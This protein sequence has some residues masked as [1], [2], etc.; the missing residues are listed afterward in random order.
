MYLHIVNEEKKKDD[1][2]KKSRSKIPKSLRIL[3]RIF[4]GILI[5][6]VLLILF[7]RSPW[8]QD[9][10]VNKVVSYISNETNTKVEVE[11]LFVTFAGDIALEGLY[12]EDK[13][14]D[15]LVY[16]KE[17]EADIPF[18]PIIKGKDIVIDAIDLDGLRA[19]FIRKDTI[20]GFNFQ[21]LAD[22]FA[23]TDSTAVATPADSTAS[24]KIILGDFRLK[25]IDVV[26]NDDVTGIQSRYIA[27]DLQLNMEET[28][29]E[30]MTFAA[31]ELKI[32]D[33]KIN[34]L[35]KPPLY[36]S[37]EEVPLPKF[38]VE[39]VDLK[40]VYLNFESNTERMLVELDLDEL[41]AEIP[42]INLVESSFIIDTATLKN[43]E[44]LIHTETEVNAV[45]EALEKVTD[46]V[47]QDIQQFSW[48]AIRLSLKNIDFTNNSFTYLVGD[49]EPSENAFNPNAFALTDLDL[50]AK[51]FRIGDNSATLNL[52]SAT[53]NEIS[54]INLSRFAVNAKIDD[55]NL[56][57]DGLDLVFNGNFVNGNLSMEYPSLNALI[58]KPE[59]SK[60]DANIDRF[61]FDVNEIFK[62][63]PE[64]RK[65]PYMLSFAKK[66]LTGSIN[67]SGYMSSINLSNAT[68]NWGNTTQISASGSI[69]SAMDPD[70]IS[71]NIPNLYAKT[72][73]SDIVQ[74]VDTTGMGINLPKEITAKGSISGSP[75][76]INT[77][78][79]INTSQGV[80]SID[81]TFR[82]GN[83]I[84]FDGN[85][86][87]KQF[88]LQE[89]LN[90]E[91]LGPISVTL[92]AKG[93]GTDINHL[94]AEVEAVIDS[95]Q[96]NSY[97][98]KDLK[99]N[100]SIKNGKGIVSSKYK[101]QNLNLDL[102]SYVILDSIAPEAQIK[103]NLVGADLQGLG[104]S[105][106]DIRTGFTLVADFKG[107]LTSYDF[108][109]SVDDGVVVYDD[110]TYL[111]GDINAMAHVRADTTSVN[112][113]NKLIDFNLQSNTD[114][115]TF[116]TALQ[117][118][119]YSYFYRDVIIADTIENPVNVKLKG[120]IAQAPILSEV[121]FV[122]LT[123][124]DTMNIDMDFR[125]KERKLTAAISA[126]HINYSSIEIDSLR[127][128]MNTDKDKFVFDLNFNEIN[129]GP[130]SI[131]KTIISGNQVDNEMT[132][133]FTAFHDNDPLIHIRSEVTGNRDDLR[134]HVVPDSLI[135][136]KQKW[137]VPPENEMHYL[138]DKLTFN[139]FEFSRE[140]QSVIISD[141]LPGFDV[142][143]VGIDFY[144]FKLSE[145]LNYLN[146]NE[147][148]ATGNLNGDIVFEKPFTDTG[149]L[150]DLVIKE[151]SFLDV[152]MGTLQMNGNELGNNNYAF[153]LDIAGGAVDLDLVGDY[154]ADGNEA[155]I[156][157]DL[158]I[159]EVKM[160]ALEGFS[161]GQIKDGD[162]SFSGG[163]K[164]NGTL[165]EPDYNGSLIFK[166]ADFTVAMLNAPFTLPNEK[167]EVDNSGISMNNFTF[168]DSNENE[169]V[170]SGKIGTESF[171]NPTFD[172]SLSADHFEALNATEEDNDLFYGLAT[173]DAD[174][175]ITGDLQIPI[176]QGS[177]KV[178]KDTDV[179]YVMPAAT[180]NLEQRDGIVIFVNKENPDAILTRSEE[181]V[182]TIKGFDLS[183]YFTVEQ[184]AAITIVLDKETGD[185]FKVEGEG[186]FNFN[187]FPNGT[188]TL[189]GTYNIT[190]GHYEMHLYNLVNRTFEL[191]DGSKIRWSGDPFDADLDITAIYKI[192][193][194][195]SGLM[196]AGTSSLA[197][198]NRNR[199]KQ[200]LPFY[201]YLN[202]DG[203]LT[204][205]KISFALDM[206][207]DEQGAI[208]GQVFGRVQ[209]INSQEGELN[210]QVFS[211]LVLNKFYP[212]SG[213][214]GSRGG[215]AS[216]AR[217]NLNDALSDQLNVFSDKLLGESGIELDF[218]LD[219]FTDYQGESPQERTQLDI[220]AQKKLFDDKVIVRVGS[221]VDVQGTSPTGE[222]TPLIG[223]V[224]VEY[225]LTN[226]G[227]Y[228]VKGFRRNEFENVIDGQTIVSGI[229]LIFTQEFNQFNEL[230]DALV[231]SKTEEEKKIAEE[232]KEA[233][234]KL[235]E[236]DQAQKAENNDNPADGN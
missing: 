66:P 69:E 231:K 14:G 236:K 185:N 132:L 84:A 49:A 158:R 28:D 202:V 146:P 197:P 107:N 160:A 27:Q 76:S 128:N 80:A 133:D 58:E 74:F 35:Q 65:N 45:T 57:V 114:P 184:G 221:E 183:T 139:Q 88:Q 61:R 209:E 86:Q 62:F 50:Q 164:L 131:Q 179:T 89:F 230:W 147:V 123:D 63:Q 223:N 159:N 155:K 165:L 2:K 39:T 38:S 109:A 59:E 26:Y 105:R 211:L 141:N 104:F 92:N 222:S 83:D 55:T 85:V 157:L 18:G 134:L 75:T 120:R 175:K 166:D 98:I 96:L 121:F 235:N 217:D 190:G 199:F 101:D 144:N 41:Y 64:L 16:V 226:D 214:D 193:T 227:R 224:S 170:A 162:G 156:D 23:T 180:V 181:Q 106:R 142:D 60:I 12:L 36:V 126:P 31:S 198:E 51:E 172:L 173:F 73:E 177:A 167:I 33:A 200:V 46:E 34:I 93:Q 140:Q 136:N 97:A 148:L 195:A 19:N 228:R 208:G 3:G 113:K 130:L 116:S 95:F 17:M 192:E 189:A 44:I 174:F 145:F 42:E 176:I 82:S 108:K 20:N 232:V 137:I 119:I 29:L 225:I 110:K 188:M 220:A 70:R 218:N 40:N 168:K 138:G 127:F 201:V 163:F 67:A 99:I 25:N 7:I 53:F 102:E 81:G 6:F 204:A 149:I 43:S 150:A 90:N 206:P 100:G 205:P 153:N 118:H 79:N 52:S 77:S 13:K 30:T 94:D 203:E 171:I 47:K 213:S 8:G 135:L 22:A 129:G 234:Q 111:L 91:Q 154:I 124:L 24:Q 143:H 5:F 161:Q 178:L 125:Q 182:G 87:I 122:N 78:M 212:E 151:L 187:M 15:T 10:I 56:N 9:I 233:E 117:Q 21:F 54:G 112:V 219:T 215:F 194:S 207:E 169:L 229:A 152:D 48:P 186:E 103:L 4:L 11:S 32:T 216:I 71:F 115:Q 196:A 210:R 72:I 1:S 191:A 68:V 37:E